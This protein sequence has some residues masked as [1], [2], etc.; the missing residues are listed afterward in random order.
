ML[1][2]HNELT[3]EKCKDAG[4]AL[5]LLGLICYHFWPS[6][7]I[8]LSTIVLLLAA[9]TWPLI[10]WPF[11]KFWFALSSLLGAVVSKILLTVLF[12]LLVLPVGLIRRA[13]GK[14]AMRK[15]SWKQG[16]GSVFRLREH[17]FSARDL[18]HPY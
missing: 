9:M 12:I 7:L 5:V 17:D 18:E 6:P 14:D 15:K 3:A 13:A 4:L 8:M 2:K 10:F 1:D 11:A 16:N